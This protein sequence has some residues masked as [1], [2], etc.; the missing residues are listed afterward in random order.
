M[1]HVALNCC[2]RR[3]WSYEPGMLLLPG[4]WARWDLPF[5]CAD[6]HFIVAMLILVLLFFVTQGPNT[7]CST[8]SACLVRTS[9]LGHS[10][11]SKGILS[12]AGWT[13]TRPKEHNACCYRTWEKLPGWSFPQEQTALSLL[14]SKEQLLLAAVGDKRQVQTD[15]RS[16]T[17]WQ[18]LSR[19]SS[20]LL[21]CFV[22]VIDPAGDV[23]GLPLPS[24]VSSQPPHSD[25]SG[26]SRGKILAHREKA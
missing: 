20:A 23:G 4:R 2:A 10:I 6:L 12:S 25:T 24:Q 7:P 19:L 15:S 21:E 22:W 13:I 17:A 9:L 26:Q 18:S 5:C 14:I 1:G 3:R 16:G 8:A 11:P